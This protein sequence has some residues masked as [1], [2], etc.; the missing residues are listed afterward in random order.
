MERLGRE[1][2]RLAVID[3]KA[4]DE[5]RGGALTIEFERTASGERLAKLAGQCRLGQLLTPDEFEAFLDHQNAFIS[6]LA[7]PPT[8]HVNAV[9]EFLRDRY[10][11]AFEPQARLR[12]NDFWMRYLTLGHVRD[13][14]DLIRPVLPHVVSR[15][16]SLD[17]HTMY[18]GTTIGP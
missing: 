18:L 2:L 1:L 7:R 3:S 17:P 5:Y 9:P 4:R 11:A 6:G 10:L 15:A 16:R 8:E 13:W 12:P 14:C